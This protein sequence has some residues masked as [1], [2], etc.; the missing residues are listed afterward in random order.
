MG[1]EQRHI[2]NF[3]F[4]GSNLKYCVCVCLCDNIILKIPQDTSTVI[5][6]V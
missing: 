3:L 1:R 2:E 6:I 5:D 4:H